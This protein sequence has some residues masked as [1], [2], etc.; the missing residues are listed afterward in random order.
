MSSTALPAASAPAT[1]P[2]I[3]AARRFVPTDLDPADVGQLTALADALLQRE[4]ATPEAVAQWLADYAELAAV[5]SEA[6]ARRSIAKACDTD[7]DA[8]D[9]AYQHWIQQ[10]APALAPLHDKLHRKYLASDCRDRLDT[11][12]RA[13]MDK[14][15]QADVDLYRDENVPL[16]VEVKQA[17]VGY[18]KLIGAMSI[19]LDG[20]TL[21]LPQ[22]AAHLESTD[23]A[24]RETVWRKVVERRLEDRDAIDGIFDELLSKRQTIAENAGLD[25]FRAYQWRS[26]GRFDY[27]P[28]D[29]DA[30]ADAVEQAVVPELAKR[31]RLRRERLGVESL[32]PWDLGVDPRGRSPLS[33]FDRDRTDVLVDRTKALLTELDPALGASFGRLK[34]GR[35]LD[36]ESRKAKRAGGF[37]AS[38]SES[39]EPFIFMNA[40]G[41]HRDVDT[42]LHE[43]GHAFHF[44]A[45]FEA[46]PLMFTR[47]APMEFCEVAS[48]AMELLAG[49]YLGAFYDDAEAARARVTHVE[50]I[51]RVF[52][53]IATIDQ[54][55][56]W[57]YTH[58]GHSR[59]DR[60]AA[61]VAIRDRFDT[62]EVDW[63]GLDDAKAADWQKQL[64]LFH[65]PFYYIEYGIAQM[66]ALQVWAN[67]RRD[68][69]DALARYRAALKLGGTRPLP[70]LFE[71]AGATFDLGPATLAPLVR[72]LVDELD[73]LDVD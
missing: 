38:L 62:A 34:P 42:M 13:L 39:G 16:Q 5:I 60:T 69:A 53:W 65:H 10:V 51:L 30:F 43:A 70:E 36:L 20:Q 63:S 57:L 33:P 14:H 45:S 44:L 11:P 54:F 52:P 31:H 56:H 46:V 47:H 41:V 6:G 55:Q 48:M 22:A 25:D 50:S 12:G 73:R 27:T 67:A 1:D 7:S 68:P 24:H 2:A 58:P 59:D 40:A 21:T 71:A 28:A 61:W 29:C 8:V 9:A 64:H 4:L 32:R 3:V 37:Q 66:G 15:W 17:V 35:N 19:E 26:F 23:R 49:P 72:D 18:D